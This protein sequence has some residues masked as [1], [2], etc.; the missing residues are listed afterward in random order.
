MTVNHPCA[1]YKWREE[2][3]MDGSV[4][5]GSSG[6]LVLLLTDEFYVK[7]RAFQRGYD[8]LRLLEIAYKHFKYNNKSKSFE[9]SNIDNRKILSI[10]E[11]Q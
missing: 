7:S 5:S 2:F 6:S 11:L 3:V 10:W 8:Q 9:S 4:Y 1:D